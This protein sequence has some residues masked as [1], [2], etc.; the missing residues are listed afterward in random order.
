MDEVVKLQD[1]SIFEGILVDYQQVLVKDNPIKTYKVY[2]LG[3]EE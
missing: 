3:G 2:Q 1:E